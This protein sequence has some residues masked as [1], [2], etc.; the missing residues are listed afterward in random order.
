MQENHSCLELNLTYKLQNYAEDANLLGKNRNIIKKITETW[1]RHSVGRT[2]LYLHVS[3]EECRI[4]SYY[5]DRRSL[6][7]MTKF[8]YFGMTVTNQDSL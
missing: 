8:K 3:S 7:N 2:L 4:K 5:K 6:E 1:F